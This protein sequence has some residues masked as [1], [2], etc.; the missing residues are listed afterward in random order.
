MKFSPLLIF[1]CLF[2]MALA[3]QFRI[4]LESGLAF[5]QYNDVR[6]PNGEDEKGTL[7]S[8][9]DDFSPE[10]PAPF[11]RLELGYLINQK[12]TIEFT[13]A[14]L[15]LNYQNLQRDSIN[16]AGTTF[17]GENINGRYEFNT[18]RLS[19]RYRLIRS[20]KISL[21]LGATLLIRDARIA[22]TQQ[23]LQAEDVD[24]GFVPLISFEFNYAPADLLSLLLKGDALVGPQGRA[25]DIFG[26]MLFHFLD[27]RFQLK[28]GYRFIE[29]G[30]DV[31]QVYNFAFVH[32]MDLG[33][34]YR[35]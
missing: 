9:T 14:P 21:D 19:Y 27:D 12:H 20:S 34:I 25:E 35:L 22:I 13:A 2:P 11:F 31:E 16:F 15:I 18:Y 26:G 7:F 33:V 1:F 24:L 30:A 10:E 29:G 32:F 3:A 4:G 6:V 23:E 8:L 17:N 5:S 28:A